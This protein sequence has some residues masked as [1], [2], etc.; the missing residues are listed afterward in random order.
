GGTVDMGAVE[1]TAT[2]APIFVTTNNPVI[3]TTDA[4][5][6]LPEAIIN[7]NDDAA[8]YSD[9]AAGNGQDLLRLQAGDYTIPAAYAAGNGLP[10]ITSSMEIEGNGATI[11]RNPGS[12]HYR[13]LKVASTGDLTLS[14]ATITGGDGYGSYTGGVGIY[15]A[16]VPTIT[17][18]TI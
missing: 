13:I 15:N 12:G 16:G 11:R 6:S 18:S 7:A 2:D 14:Y 1:S 5:C 10:I 17:N 4:R 3:D 8:T 9:C